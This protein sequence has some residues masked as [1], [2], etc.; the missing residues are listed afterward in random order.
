MSIS[1]KKINKKKSNRNS[2]KNLLQQLAKSTI[3][4]EQCLGI[5]LATPVAERIKHVV[6]Q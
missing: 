5:E 4:M 1:I 2:D 6:I 3:P